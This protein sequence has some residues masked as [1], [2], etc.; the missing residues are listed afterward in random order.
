MKTAAKIFLILS[1]ISESIATIVCIIFTIIFGLNGD[2]INQNVGYDISKFYIAVF[3]ICLVL[4]AIGVLVS[5]LS[6]K[7]LGTATSKKELVPY[8]VLCL[9]FSGIV[10]G[11]LLLCIDDNSLHS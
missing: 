4:C 1:I 10:P 5:V 2:L 8:G 7:K 3:V 9:I 11:I 6:L